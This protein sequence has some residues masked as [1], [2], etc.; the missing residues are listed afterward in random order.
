MV[1]G[2]RRFS[3]GRSSSVLSFRRRPV[4]PSI[5]ETRRHNNCTSFV[6][7]NISMGAGMT[8][9]FQPWE[10]IDCA[11]EYVKKLSTDA[12]ANWGILYCGGANAI[13][14]QLRH[15]AAEYDLDL[16]SEAFSW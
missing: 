9:A 1:F 4:M 11:D 12:L 5:G 7:R 10:E 15:T 8:L 13:E 2:S 6:R 14:K 3:H 16:H